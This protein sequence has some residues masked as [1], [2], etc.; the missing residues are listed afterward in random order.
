MWSIK[1]TS[2]SFSILGVVEATCS[3]FMKM[4]L[5]ANKSD[6]S[7]YNFCFYSFERWCIAYLETIQSTVPP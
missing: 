2:C 3:I 5:G 7:L 1:I 6:I 4:P